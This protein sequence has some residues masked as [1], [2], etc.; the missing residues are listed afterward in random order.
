MN[1]SK[2][3]AALT[4]A[5]L[6]L[7]ATAQTMLGPTPYLQASDSP[8]NVTTPA[9]ALETFEDHLLNVPGVTASGGLVTSTQFSGSIIDSVDADDGFVN[10]VCTGCDSYF[11]GSGPLTFTFSAAALGG[12]PKKAGLVWTDGGGGC[13]ATFTAYDANG[14]LLGTLVAPLIGDASNTGTTAEDRFF[15]I[16]YAGGIAQIRILNSTGGLEVDHLQYELPCGVGPASIYCTAKTNSLGCVPAIGYEGC[17]SASSAGTFRISCANVLSNKAGLL[18]YGYAPSA[19]PFQGGFMCV[20]SPVRRT[21]IQT[22]G[23]N[24]PPDTCTGTFSFQMNAWIQSGSDPLLVSGTT[25]HAQY[26]YRD[27]ASPSTT[28]LSNALSF[29]I[30]P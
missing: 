3:A 23:G 14:V 20:Q 28:G 5:C 7:P 2:I 12:L 19:A 6:A 18:F 1:F 26:W 29:T 4:C 13:N 25:A 8:W 16:E 22:S 9:F 21:A 27:P 15:G 10:G 24:P 17:P 11:L 30:R